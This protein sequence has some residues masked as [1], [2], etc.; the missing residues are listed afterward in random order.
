MRDCGRFSGRR[1]AAPCTSLAN[2]IR[3]TRF[4]TMASCC[5]A[6]QRPC[7]RYA[8][9]VLFH[10]EAA[11]AHGSVHCNSVCLQLHAWS[12][13]RQIFTRMEQFRPNLVVVRQH[14]PSRQAAAMAFAHRRLFAGNSLAVSRRSMAEVFHHQPRQQ[15]RACAFFADEEMHSLRNDQHPPGKWGCLSIA[16]VVADQAP[17]CWAAAIW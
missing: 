7:T 6:L 2:S 9:C 8:Q 12:N 1:P 11:R 5:C 16:A 3:A 10:V 13:H 14:I 4:R 17:S 15:R